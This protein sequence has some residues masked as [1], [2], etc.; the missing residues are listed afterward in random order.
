[1]HIA[2]IACDFWKLVERNFAIQESKRM[3]GFL[4]SKIL[5]WMNP[6]SLSSCIW[7]CVERSIAML[8]SMWVFVAL[9]GSCF[10][11]FRSTGIQKHHARL[12][13]FLHSEIAL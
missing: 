13:G 10:A 5:L 12:P 1:M 6:S 7:V 3:S 9:V 2:G 11:K 8:E 4:Y